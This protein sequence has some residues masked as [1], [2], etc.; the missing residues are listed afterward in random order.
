MNVIKKRITGFEDYT[1]DSVGN[2]KKGNKIISSHETMKGY[3]RINL[4]RNK[5]NSLHYVHRLVAETF[6]PKQERDGQKLFVDHIDHDRSNNCFTN[7]RWLTH[8]EN[9]RNRRNTKG[10]A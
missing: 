10:V 9:I 3:R 1:I 7:L 8:L 4:R 6:I 5:K 2:V